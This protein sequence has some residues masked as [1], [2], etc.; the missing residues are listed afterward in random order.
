LAESDQPP[1]ASPI[2][3]LSSAIPNFGLRTSDFGLRTSPSHFPLPQPFAP[4]RRD[5]P[6]PRESINYQPS[7]PSNP[8]I[9]HQQ[10][11]INLPSAISHLQFPIRPMSPIRPIT[12]TPPCPCRILKGCKALSPALRGTSYAGSPHPKKPGNPE[13][14]CSPSCTRLHSQSRPF[15]PFRP[16]PLARRVRRS[17]DPVGTPDGRALSPGKPGA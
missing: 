15:C 1:R 4:E 9:N 5:V 7:P 11:T 13:S 2:S 6:T 8:S 14:G 10:S 17:A 3:H 16:S 12:P